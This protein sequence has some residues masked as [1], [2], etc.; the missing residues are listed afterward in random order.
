MK[1]IRVGNA[2]GFWGDSPAAPKD[3]VSSG[4]LD[5]LTLEYL[6]ELT[7]SILAHQKK[8]DPSKGYVTEVPC[9]V[10]SIQQEFRE[11]GSLRLVTNGG[12]M[13]PTACAE[14]VARVLEHSSDPEMAELGIGVASGDDIFPRLNELIDAGET[15]A[16][17]ETGDAISTIRNRIASANVYLGAAGITNCLEQGARI[18]LTGRVADASLVLGPVQFEHGWSD[19]DFEKLAMATVAG[20][21][22]EC[23]AQV[24]GGIFSRWTPDLQLGDVGYPIAVIDPSG[25]GKITKVPGSGGVV[26]TRTCAEQLVYEIGDPQNYMTPDVIADFSQVRFFQDDPDV[27][28]FEG[29]TGHQRPEKLKVSIAYYDGFFAS[30][31]IVVAGRRAV[32]KARCAGEMIRQRLARDGIVLDQF[33]YEV[34]GSGDSAMGCLPVQFENVEADPW[35]VVLRVSGRSSHRHHTDRMLRELAPLVTSG[36]PGVTGYTGAR[37][38]SRPVLSFWPALISREHCQISSLVKAAKDWI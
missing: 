20:H 14:Q 18:V 21:L 10:E 34:L 16:N 24:T 29:G 22:I 11:N 8:K 37:G 2:A 12:G 23:G 3:L 4:N 38:Q 28:S 33:H 36:P 1:S 5:Y 30:G 13:N 32:E 26:S 17:M 31:M 6:A 35:E 25:R 9:V 19:D 7:L 15:L 27:V